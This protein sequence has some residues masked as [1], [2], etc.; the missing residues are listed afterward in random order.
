MTNV[1]SSEFKARLK[2]EVKALSKSHNTTE[3]KAFGIWFAVNI[4]ELSEADA[5]SATQFDGPNDKSVDLLWVDDDREA[6]VI[7][8]FK[9]SP[10]LSFS[11]KSSHLAS[12]QA[13]INWL[14][15]PNALKKDGK[16]DL[17]TAAEEYCEALT[18]GYATEFWYVYA[19][20]R[21][22]HIENDCSV[23]NQNPD[24]VEK[25]CQSCHAPL[26][27]V[28]TQY[29]ELQDASFHIP[30]AKIKIAKGGVLNLSGSFGQALVAT[31]P[32]AELA[33]LYSKHHD[34]L[35]EANVRLFLGARKNSVN[36][37]IYATLK[38]EKTRGNFWAYN[39]GVTFLCDKVEV[40]KKGTSVSIKNF[41][42]VNGCQTTTLLS[43]NSD[44][45]ETASLLVRFIAAPKKII[46][47]VILYN[48]SQNPVRAWDIASRFKTQRRLRREFSKLK[49][50]INYWT[51]RGKRPA[52]TKKTIP[53][54]T[55][56]P[57]ELVGQ[58][59]AAAQSKPVLA[60]K[61]KAFVFQNEHDSVFRPDITPLEVLFYYICGEVCS[62]AV[63]EKMKDPETDDLTRR[64]LRSGGTLFV[65]A[66]TAEILRT[67][68]GA[69]FL[70]GLTQERIE[71]SG[72]TE[73]LKKYVEFS[74]LSYVSAVGLLMTA[75]SLELSTLIRSKDF[76]VA[77]CKS[78][79]VD[80]A[81][82]AVNKSWLKDALPLVQP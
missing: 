70:G 61:H 27:Y 6:V 38:D 79:K 74:L 65:L 76:F 58:Y 3:D 46:N 25:A 29:L 30:D 51:R 15:N 5:V 18:K 53:K 78:V 23:F 62:A 17:A 37:G 35:F 13:S 81:K 73:K 41:S 45:L 42:I 49:R 39:N 9:H 22:K 48:N 34:R 55:L 19:G 69:T 75:K 47:D 36:Y 54:P 26:D 14:K 77:V 50:P 11:A 44:L 72:T 63:M 12:L 57:F 28:E 4:M 33:A 52:G 56:L 71:S 7:G 64:I 1:T 66:T 20:P 80:Y 10:D 32:A 21:S 24:N 59:M 60:W 82:F 67:R 8:Q 2:A 68:N 43:Q 31:V 16:H 40:D